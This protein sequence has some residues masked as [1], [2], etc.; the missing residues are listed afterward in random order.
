MAIVFLPNPHNKGEVNHKDNDGKNNKL[1]NLE[2]VTRSENIQH[3]FDND[4]HIS[5]KQIKVKLPNGDIVKYNSLRHAA[6]ELKIHRKTIAKYAN[7]NE[8][9][10]GYQFIEI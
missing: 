5:A 6:R 4:Y 7:N 1:T 10:K 2:W 9:F 3:L 8:K